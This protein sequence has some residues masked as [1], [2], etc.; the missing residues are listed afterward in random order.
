M[1]KLQNDAMSVSWNELR[2][3]IQSNPHKST[4]LG[5]GA[6][7]SSIS[8]L[9][10]EI[11]LPWLP[12]FSEDPSF[13]ASDCISLLLWIRDPMYRTATEGV[14]RAMEKEEASSLLHSIDGA[15]KEHNGKS[16]GWIRKHLEE[17]LRLRAGGGDALPD[18][19]EQVRTQKRAG[20]LVDYIC[21][22]RNLRLGLWWPEQKAVSNIP[23]SGSKSPIIQ[24]NC[25]TCHVIMGPDGLEI[26]SELWPAHLMK[27]DLQ[28]ITPAC[29]PSIGAN[30]VSQIQEKLQKYTTEAKGNRAQLWTRLMFETM[31]ADAEYTVETP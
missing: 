15:W 31:I 8:A 22:M 2:D 30:T 12:G 1:G 4:T 14:R 19:W 11:M 27:T 3:A 28:W 13:S 24:L 7:S 6:A 17:D 26:Q 10:E 16:R 29:A 18:A 23:L 21:I 5:G 20:Q 25:L 9:P